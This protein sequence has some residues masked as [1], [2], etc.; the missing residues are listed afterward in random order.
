ML[1]KVS[2]SGLVAVLLGAVVV[3]AGCTQTSSASEKEGVQIVS[4]FE[5]QLGQLPE[6][7]AIDKPGNIYVS[8]GYPFWF[9]VEESFGEIWKISPG[10]EITVLHAFPGGPGAAGG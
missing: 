8:V 9:P 7:I 3:I 1:R 2:F 5:G 6:G 4:S 10:G